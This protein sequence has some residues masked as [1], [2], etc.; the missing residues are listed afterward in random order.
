MAAQDYTTTIQ[1][2]YLAFYGRF[3]DYAG[4]NYWAGQLDKQGGSLSSIIDAFANSQESKALYGGSDVSSTITK[5]YQQV[6]NRAP[7]QGG[8]SWYSLQISTG[9][10]TLQSIALDVLNSATGSDLT[11][12]NNKLQFSTIATNS[13]HT[14]NAD[15]LYA[16]NAVAD[17]VRQMLSGINEKTDSATINSNANNV[18]NKLG[19]VNPVTSQSQTF[20]N[21]LITAKIYPDYIFHSGNTKTNIAIEQTWENASGSGSVEGIRTYSLS[22]DFS[23][24][25]YDFLPIFKDS[26][27]T[28]VAA[29]NQQGKIAIATDNAILL[30]DQGSDSYTA[31]KL[32]SSSTATDSFKSITTTANGN[33][34]AVGTENSVATG[35]HNAYAVILDS[36]GNKVAE[37]RFEDSANTN[38]NNYFSKAW[39][40]SDGESVLVKK[41]DVNVRKY[42]VADANLNISKSFSFTGGEYLTELIEDG[43]G[44][45]IG[46]RDDD[47]LLFMDKN[48]SV[49]GTAKLQFDNMYSDSKSWIHDIG[50]SNG[51]LY[52]VARP[53]YDKVNKISYSD[54]SLISFAGASANA[55]VTDVK[56]VKDKDDYGVDFRGLSEDG[57]NSYLY[58]D[59]GTMAIIKNDVKVPANRNPGY[60]I[61][62]LPLSG[63]LKAGGSADFAYATNTGTFHA[64][65]ISL[66]GS[67][68]TGTAYHVAGDSWGTVYNLGSVTA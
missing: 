27:S 67:P 53:G 57:G 33:F 9:K 51:N 10:T 30:H 24:N 15:Q 58:T 25:K 63:S 61:S 64:A 35:G 4:L 48:F 12:V 14:S 26:S 37:Q 44:G 54:Y 19:S 36:A 6:L 68:T 2:A 62:E 16:G 41:D 13:L 38:A 23:G 8:L 47:V 11:T 59:N 46:L 22:D 34:L 50:I 42:Y 20:N 43:K 28:R 65:D 5:I 29:V 55:S 56:V 60:K 66:V 45:Y 7:D 32:K 1:K 21:T 40:F 18:S 49:S 3:A 31:V 17:Q 39:T 52:A